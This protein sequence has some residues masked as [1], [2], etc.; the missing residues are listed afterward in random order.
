[1]NA[2]AEQLDYRLREAIEG[3]TPFLLELCRSA[4]AMDPEFAGISNEQ[5]TAIV[6]FQHDLQR[7]TIAAVFPGA[8]TSIVTIEGEP[9]GQVIVHRSPHSMCLIDIELLPRFRGHGVGTRIVGSLCEEA[10]SKRIPLSLRVAITNRDAC[11]LYKR[12]GFIETD[13]DEQFFDMTFGV[14]LS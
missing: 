8:K 14:R 6:T 13:A 7:Q 9:A 12:L 5:Q 2:I 11:R 1:M 3:D 4:R 10:A